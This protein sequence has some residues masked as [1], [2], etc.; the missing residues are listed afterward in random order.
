[1][2]PKL[3][4]RLINTRHNF[5]ILQLILSTRNCLGYTLETTVVLHGVV[6]FKNIP[7]ILCY[8]LGERKNAP[9]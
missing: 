5:V 4:D 2:K 1:M 6:Y 7:S 3:K 8:C 9:P